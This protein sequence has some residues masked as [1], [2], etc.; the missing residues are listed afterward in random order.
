MIDFASSLWNHRKDLVDSKER[1]LKLREAVDRP[2][3]QD[4]ADWFKLYAFVLEYSP[5]LIIELG[6]GYG[7]STC[8]FTEAVNKIG[9]LFKL[10]L[11]RRNMV[12]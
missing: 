1:L 7:N 3:D 11:K 8:I 10:E 9:K 2:G 6:R 12:F 4:L 5:D